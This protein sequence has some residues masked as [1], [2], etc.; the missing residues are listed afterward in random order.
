MCGFFFL[1]ACEYCYLSLS[2]CVCNC[3]G[4]LVY[5]FK[6]TYVSL[7]CHSARQV[8]PVQPLG[9]RRCP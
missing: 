2:A 8:I 4:A 7:Q 1:K 3:E 6:G 9:D 5:L